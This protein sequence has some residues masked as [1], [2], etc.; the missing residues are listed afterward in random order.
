MEDLKAEETMSL[1]ETLSNELG[2][3]VEEAVVVEDAPE[4]MKLIHFSHIEGVDCEEVV[5]D[6]IDEVYAL[7]EEMVKFCHEKQ[8]IGLAAPQIGVFKKFFIWLDG[9]KW[10]LAINPTYF[11]DKKNTVDLMERCLSYP[12]RYFKVKRYKRISAVFYNIDGKTGKLKKYSRQLSGDRA[13]VFQHE[14]DHLSGKTVNTEG[15]EMTA[16][17]PKN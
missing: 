16:R 13:W 7:T 8:G 10:S 12:E 14:C 15:V 1:T 2:T 3:G 17:K 11:P 5:E 9:D 4:K 6:E